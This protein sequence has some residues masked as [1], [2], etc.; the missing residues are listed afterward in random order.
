MFGLKR[1]EAD[2]GLGPVFL[3]LGGVGVMLAVPAAATI[4]VLLRE[5][6]NSTRP[7]SGHVV[8]PFSGD[9]DVAPPG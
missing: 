7:P 4:H 3:L 2:D 5:I 8:S 6:W 1:T 9:D